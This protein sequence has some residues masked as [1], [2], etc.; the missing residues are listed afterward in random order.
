MAREAELSLLQQLVEEG[1]TVPE[2]PSG[3]VLV[4]PAG[5]G[6]TALLAELLGSVATTGRP[7]AR[8]IATRSAADTPF[9]ALA[10]LAPTVSPAGHPDLSTW[11][12]TFAESLRTNDGRRPVLAVDDAH[13]LDAGSA[14]LVLHLAITRAATVVV[15]CRRGEDVPDPVTALWRDDLVPRVD[16]QPFSRQE[17][18]RMVE[19]FLGDEV[20]TQTLQRLVAV[21]D[22]NVLYVRE[23]LL[24]ALD[25]G[26]LRRGSDG[27][28][29]WDGSLVLAPRLVDAVSQRLTAL[30][31]AQRHALALLC[32][33]EPLALAHMERIADPQ[34]LAGLERAGL[35][36]VV[37][38]GGQPEL[39]LD[40]PLHGDVVLSRVGVVEQRRL[41][42][43]LADEVEA[44]GTGSHHETLRVATWRLDGGGEVDAALLTEAAVIANQAFD[45]PLAE[46]LGRAARD[47]GARGLSDVA[48]A[49]ALTTQ[50]RHEEAEQVFRDAEED[51]LAIADMALH[52]RYLHI[53]HIA[54]YLGLGRPEEQLALLERFDRSHRASG[55]PDRARVAGQLAAGYR[56]NVLLDA[57]RLAEVGR[58]TEPILAE[59]AD[60]GPLPTLL[61]LEVQGEALAYAG[62]TAQARE[63]HRRLLDLAATGDPLVVAP[64][65]RPSCRRC[66]AR[67]SR[68]GAPRRWRSCPWSVSTLS[69]T[70]TPTSAPWSRWCSEAPSC[71]PGVPSRYAVRCG[72]H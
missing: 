48:L 15:A 4:G 41:R 63:L 61:A 44:H 26:A 49:E 14:A 36:R 45:R 23:L 57:G 22:G 51:I 12:R 30:S 55:D 3:A 67:C 71:T 34:A 50:N 35:A 6:K 18:A 8:T 20:S 60:V 65:P 19:T 17:T 24:G 1:D 53:R 40:H 46:K 9:A 2:R 32:V 70:P 33:G 69:T 21:S 42:R 16:L 5:V 66:C 56:A 64:S 29:H 62:R 31:D 43:V 52:Q 47:R 7:V 27:V 10:P 28:W 54:L 25:A 38:S 13:L 59:G 58:V 11:F 68:A 39:R 72:R 37:E